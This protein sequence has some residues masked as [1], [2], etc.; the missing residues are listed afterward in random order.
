MSEIL[1]LTHYPPIAHLNHEM[2]IDRTVYL[3]HI[4]RLRRAELPL[5]TV[6]LARYL[7]GKLLVREFGQ[8][9]AKRTVR[10]VGRLVG[11][12]VGRIVETEAYLVGDAAAHTFRGPT[13]RN[14]P[15]YLEHGH[16]YVYFIYG[17]HYLLNVSGARAGVGEGVLLRACEPLE[18][19]ERMKRHRG[20]RGTTR[21][22]DLARG[23]GNLAAAMQVDRR[24]DGLDLCGAGSLWL[25]APPRS[26]RRPVEVGESVR[27]GI[28]RDAH[29]VL[30]FYERGSP[31][32]SGPKRLRE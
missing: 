7:I 32:V 3:G 2:S 5:N 9:R 20:H 26:L 29:R 28:Q 23:P 22:T 18:G 12:L 24:F 15:L 11:R 25:G 27:I 16:A 1:K 4:R 14:R 8:G 13:P 19:I 21:L 31:F 17:N 6:K 30:R 10:P